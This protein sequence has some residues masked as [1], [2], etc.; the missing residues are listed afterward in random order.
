MRKSKL[1]TAVL[2]LIVAVTVEVPGFSQEGA[3][4]QV[5]TTFARPIPMGS[6]CGNTAPGMQIYT[7]TCGMLTEF[8]LN[9]NVLG[10]LS[11]NHVLGA[12][13]NPAC[14]NN[15]VPFQT[16]TVQ[17]GTLDGGSIPADIV[18]VVA[19]FVP[20]DFTFGASNL[21]D[22]A[23]SLTTSGLSNNNILTL[24]SPNPELDGGI[25]ALAGMTVTKTG[26]TTDT[27]V[28]TV[29]SI[30]STVTVRYGSC[31]D[32]RFVNQVVITGI[33]GPFSLGGDSGSVILDQSNNKPVSLLYA[34]ST[35]PPMTIGNQ[36]L[37]VYLSLGFLPVGW[38]TPGPG[39]EPLEATLERQLEE[40]VD[41]TTA[42]ALQIRAR[43]ESE[44]FADPQVVGLGVGLTED[45][46]GPA[47]IVYS[48]S[49]G[50]TAAALPASVDGVPVR[51][52]HS[53]GFSAYDW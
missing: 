1:L 43:V 50:Q 36:I 44:F 10:I 3:D 5:T 20:I 7:G 22:A 28:G 6:S 2:F 29:Q 51:V 21:V 8:F 41:A 17:A 46:T 49:A 9:P 15:A 25:I 24:G 26:R 30:G 45:G 47:L 32:A 4:A 48:E 52:V 34:G 12:A 19:G 35:T 23:I 37:A 40:A 42:R 39:E 14:P 38:F 11:N 16:L 18:G 33:A 27:T 13:G 53:D 31:G